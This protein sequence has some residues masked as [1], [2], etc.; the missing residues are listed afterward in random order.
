MKK[1]TIDSSQSSDY[2]SVMA[3]TLLQHN[4]HICGVGRILA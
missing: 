2:Y 3:A 4:K 1:V